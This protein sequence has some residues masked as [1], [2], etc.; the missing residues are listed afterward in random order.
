MAKSLAFNLWPLLPMTFILTLHERVPIPS[1]DRI[2]CSAIYARQESVSL[3]R[4]G[5]FHED[6]ISAWWVSQETD[7][8][9]WKH[10]TFE[11]QCTCILAYSVQVAY[12]QAKWIR[13]HRSTATHWYEMKS[14]QEDKGMTTSK[15][16]P[17]SMIWQ[18]T[19][20]F[21]ERSGHWTLNY[22]AA[23]LPQDGTIFFIGNNS[24]SMKCLH[25]KFLPDENGLEFSR[26]ALNSLSCLRNLLR[27]QKAWKVAQW[28]VLFLR[29][30][31]MHL[32]RTQSF[33]GAITSAS[34]V[35][36][37]D[38]QSVLLWPMWYVGADFCT[39]V[40]SADVSEKLHSC[41]YRIKV[42]SGKQKLYPSW[43]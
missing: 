24:T 12:I 5:T 40:C 33:V 3:R 43:I 6:S 31:K 21:C 35:R 17:Q 9:V 23:G 22:W 7:E 19:F 29:L 16:W 37:F 8:I 18:Q 42:L 15:R 30:T 36:K 39:H 34:I 41:F 25:M 20:N 1:R 28:I 26:F 11:T 10:G 32:A 38:Q 27:Q 14:W 13:I 4:C 2:A